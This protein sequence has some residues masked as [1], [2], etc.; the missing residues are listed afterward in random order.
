M[1]P[2]RASQLADGA[3]NQLQ[4]IQSWLTHGKLLKAV[5]FGEI[6]HFKNKNI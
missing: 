3:G 2:D 1:K 4:I 5:L 6:P